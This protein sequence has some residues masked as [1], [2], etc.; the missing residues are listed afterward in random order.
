LDVNYI[1]QQ[2]LWTDLLILTRTIPAVLFGKGA[3]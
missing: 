1:E 2:N 3:C